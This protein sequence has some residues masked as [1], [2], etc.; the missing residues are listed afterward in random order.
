M[1]DSTYTE[2]SADENAPRSDGGTSIRGATA[3]RVRSLSRRQFLGLTGGSVAVLGG[4]RAA[5][6]VVLGYGEFGYGTNLLEQDL[7]AMLTD[8]LNPTYNEAIGNHQLRLGS[9]GLQLIVSDV[10]YTVPFP[11]A[12]DRERGESIAEQ[13]D[14]TYGLDGR[15]PA[16]YTDLVSVSQGDFR[17][18]FSQPEPFFERV[19]EGSYRPDVVAALRGSAYDRSVD[20]ALVGE[21]T[22][23]D[24]ADPESLV[25]G[26]KSAFR[27]Y[28]RYDVPRYIAG[29]IED[30][31]IF[32]VTD[33][34]QYFED[35]VSFEA[36]LSADETGMFCWEYVFRSME[37]LQAL[38][39]WEQT[40]PVAT[41]YISDRRHKHA[42]TGIITAIEDDG[43]CFPTTF[44]DYT[45]STLYDDFRLR[46]VL[47]DGLAAYD[48][49]HRADEI[50][51]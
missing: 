22:D 14:S 37:A 42:F 49:R 46:G 30:N 51:W 9:S 20:P 15:L 23:A 39:P 50:Y 19:G 13:L 24:P 28:S 36:L 17:F 7:D 26:L 40:I 21:F 41:F 12:E 5:Y 25:Y 8:N 45:Y 6:N 16:L 1:S 47:G 33:L 48:S 43:L 35:D 31:V 27:A 44:V 38:P 3:D 29:S 10:Q 11:P 2:G 34:R 32:G 4:S 18:E